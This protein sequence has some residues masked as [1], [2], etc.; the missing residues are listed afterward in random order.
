MVQQVA[1]LAMAARSEQAGVLIIDSGTV[2]L[3]PRIWLVGERQLLS[4]TRDFHSPY[5]KHAQKCLGVS[6]RSDRL[7]YVSHHQLMQPRVV[8]KML[9]EIM[10]RC[11]DGGRADEF[12]VDS[13]LSCWIEA[14]DFRQLSALCE[15]HTYGVFLTNT[16]PQNA[17]GA[18]WANVGVARSSLVPGDLNDTRT[19]N[20]RFPKAMSVSLHAYLS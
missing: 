5:V 10:A 20:S 7:S 12:N 9:G 3:T 13:G 6:G 14:A 19:L 16:E 4:P 15:Y 8:R 18:R 2:L 11:F 1:K 17:V